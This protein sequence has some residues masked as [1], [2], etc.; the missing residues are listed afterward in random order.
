MPAVAGNRGITTPSPSSRNNLHYAR[1]G[2]ERVLIF[3]T[4]HET[5]AP[6]VCS[7]GGRRTRCIGGLRSPIASETTPLR[8]QVGFRVGDLS[9]RPGS[10]QAVAPTSWTAAQDGRGCRQGIARR[11]RRREKSRGNRSTAQAAPADARRAATRPQAP[12]IALE[13]R[14]NSECCGR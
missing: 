7:R 10:V 12:A 13:T 2:C 5:P 6:S 8:N 3:V 14:M 4:P 11:H 1:N 9:G